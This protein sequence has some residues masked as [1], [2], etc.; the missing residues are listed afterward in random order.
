MNTQ[1]DYIQFQHFFSI[2]LSV[3]REERLGVHRELE[4][5]PVL[6]RGRHSELASVR[7]GLRG[8]RPRVPIRQR[9]R[10]LL[11]WH[12]A[13]LLAL[14]PGVLKKLAA[15]QLEHLLSGTKR[16]KNE[17]P[18]NMATGMKP[19]KFYNGQKI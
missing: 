1:I 10:P 6:A 2:M 15:R 11:P 14:N 19:H 18:G 16:R 4:T 5:R 9:V 17:L 13:L 12:D 7:S 3:Y 8:A